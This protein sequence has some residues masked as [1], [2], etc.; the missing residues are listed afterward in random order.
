MKKH[1]IVDLCVIAGA[2][3]LCQAA[4]QRKRKPLSREAAEEAAEP[5]DFREHPVMAQVYELARAGKLHTYSMNPNMFYYNFSVTRYE[6]GAC[7]GKCALGDDKGILLDYPP[8]THVAYRQYQRQLEEAIRALPNVVG[9][10][11][12]YQFSVSPL[13]AGMAGFEGICG[14]NINTFYFSVTYREE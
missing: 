11:C 14:Q 10:E 8:M 1:W 12:C 2:A 9:V 4:M 13:P 6:N 7:G 3:V 5:A